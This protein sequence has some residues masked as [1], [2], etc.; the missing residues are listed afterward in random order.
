MHVGGRKCSCPDCLERRRTLSR[1]RT[2]LSRAMA[3]PSGLTPSGYTKGFYKSDALA[4]WKD[5]KALGLVVVGRSP[6]G[7]KVLALSEEASS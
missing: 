3:N 5:A 6:R 1:R 4:F 7:A 2:I